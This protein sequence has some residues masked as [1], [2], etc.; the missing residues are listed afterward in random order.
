MSTAAHASPQQEAIAFLESVRPRYE[1]E[2]FTFTIGPDRSQ[3]PTFLGD[4]APDALAK[5]PGINL[6]IEVKRHEPS[7][8]V[9]LQRISRLFDG[10]PDWTLAILSMGEK[11]PLHVRTA[12]P[13]TIRKRLDEARELVST[14]DTRAA[15]VM[16]WSLLEATLNALGT[17]HNGKPRTP[18]TVVQSLT[19]EGH[20]SQRTEENLRRLIGLR[21]RI[22]HGDVEAEPTDKDVEI[23]LAAIEEALSTGEQ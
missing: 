14:G 8:K 21:N 10:H 13:E 1:A 5:K 19:M 3:L 6:A 16:A 9:S 17:I 7:H 11:P 12:S 20:I 23:V 18:G 15:F 22:V 2:G 4:Y